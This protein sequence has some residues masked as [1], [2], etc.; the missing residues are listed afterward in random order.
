MVVMASMPSPPGRFSTT[1]GWPHFCDSLSAN[2][3]APMSTPLPA[4]SVTMKRTGRVGQASAA[5]AGLASS[6]LSASAA[7]SAPKIMVRSEIVIVFLHVPA[8]RSVRRPFPGE[9]NP[10][11]RL[12][13]PWPADDAAF[14]PENAVFGTEHRLF[15]HEEAPDAAVFDD[16]A[17]EMDLRRLGRRRGNPLGGQGIPPG[18]R[19]ARRPPR[20]GAHPRPGAAADAAARSG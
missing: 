15:E 16:A 8:G 12:A 17:G 7:V 19:G 20:A 1:I 13:H 14:S 10:Q 11:A 2:M 3:R 9:M 18:E 4:P 5:A 6:G